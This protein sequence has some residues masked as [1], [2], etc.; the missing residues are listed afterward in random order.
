[1][2]S[3][4]TFKPAAHQRPG[5]IP[6]W[7][8]NQAGHVRTWTDYDGFLFADPCRCDLGRDH[9]DRDAYGPQD[10]PEPDDQEVEADG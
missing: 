7:K 10:D 8:R 1:M 3:P 2:T 4:A 5:L 9:Y 6:T